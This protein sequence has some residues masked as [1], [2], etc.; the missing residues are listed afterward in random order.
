MALSLYRRHRRDCKA[1]HPE[2]FRTSEYDERK[3]GFKRCECP[4]FVSGTLSGRSLVAK[5]TGRWE[6]D[7]ASLSL[8]RIGEQRGAWDG[9]SGSPR[10]SL[11]PP[12]PHIHPSA[13]SSIEHRPRKGISSTSFKGTV[14]F[15]TL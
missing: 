5:S 3:K 8:Q 6:W 7:E 1:S 13:I 11:Q 9:D 15:A 10:D 4:I 12:D 14:A 2:E